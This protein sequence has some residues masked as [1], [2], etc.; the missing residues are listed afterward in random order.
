[1]VLKN[2]RLLAV[3]VL[4][5]AVTLAYGADNRTKLKP[6]LNFFSPQQDV[7]IGRQSAREAERQQQMLSD[8]QATAYIETLG[9]MLARYAPNNNPAYVYQFKIVNDTAI[10]AF[11]LPGGFLYVNR[12]AITAADNEAQI[13]GV[14]AHEIGHVVMRHGTHQASRAYV[15][16]APL[17][18][19][20]GVVGGS[21][22]GTVMGA[23]GGVGMN[24][25]FLKYSRDMET[26]ADLIGTQILHD[27]GYEPKAMVEF[28]E[29]IQAESKGNASQFLSD[30]PN[31]TNRISNVQHEIEK[32]NGALPDPKLDTPEFQDV[33]HALMNMAPPSR[34]GRPTTGG[35]GTSRRPTNGTSGRSSGTPPN[36]STRLTTYSGTDIEF[37]YPDNWR[38]SEQG[39]TITV[40]P[41]GGMINGSL[42]WG[43]MVSPFQPDQQGQ[44][45][46]SLD[47]ATD[48]LLNNLQRNN[49]AMH[50]TRRHEAIRVGGQSGY[51]AEASNDSPAGGR[52]TDWIV[53]TIAPNGKVYYFV[54]V[55][56]QNDYSTYNL[57][58][59]DIIDT[60]RF[61]N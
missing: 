30:H 36:P 54:G 28:F 24:V 31:P 34:S 59:Q 43:L 29:K 53:T 22:I 56:P 14:I 20:G 49:S 39:T 33:K 27:A 32:L 17:A 4:I 26:Q 40:A 47:D 13:A 38:D 18:V 35:P 19:L 8:R 11:A 7:E 1:M 23:V 51:L 6:G 46:V 42:T 16:Q 2:S 15:A 3:L 58:F 5:V 45:P 21:A 41:D 61:R 60:V 55:A 50:F 52:E 37:R 25:L 12:G 10:N 48:Q 9:K 44:G 57:S